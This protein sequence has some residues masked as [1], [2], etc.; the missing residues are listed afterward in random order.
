MQL[1]SSKML[2][3]VLGLRDDVPMPTPSVLLDALARSMPVA[4]VEEYGVSP[5][6]ILRSLATK[7]VLE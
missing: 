4:V 2:R 1:R 3:Q 7:G 5:S 6:D